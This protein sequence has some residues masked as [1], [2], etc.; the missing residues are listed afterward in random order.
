MRVR[1]CGRLWLS[2][3]C[4]A[5]VCAACEKDQSLVADAE[6]AAREA[7]GKKRCR[8]SSKRASQKLRAGTRNGSR[9]SSASPQVPTPTPD[10]DEADAVVNGEP[11]ARNWNE[12]SAQAC[13]PAGRQGDARETAQGQLRR[14]A[15]W[16]TGGQV[17]SH[18]PCQW[19]SAPLP[20]PPLPRSSSESDQDCGLNGGVGPAEGGA[21]VVF[22]RPESRLSEGSC[23]SF[24][25]S[26]IE[27]ELCATDCASYLPL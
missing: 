9:T 19:M 7:G 8:R 15:G 21:G 27:L 14:R 12:A 10:D 23:A 4:R 11:P 16:P 6:A 5:Q 22:Q 26:E 2:D 17:E 13:A 18:E 24:A 25:G 3:V 1:V 20:L